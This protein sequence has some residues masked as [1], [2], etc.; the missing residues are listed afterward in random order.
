[1]AREMI[2]E[3]TTEMKDQS[4]KLAAK[5]IMKPKFM[6][7]KAELPPEGYHFDRFGQLRNNKTYQLQTEEQN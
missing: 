3:S 6:K 5:V 4:G 2:A 7:L 1:M